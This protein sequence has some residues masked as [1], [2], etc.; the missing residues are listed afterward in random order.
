VDGYLP[1]Y[2]DLHLQRH[3]LYDQGVFGFL[4]EQQNQTLADWLDN[5]MAKQSRDGSEIVQE[6]VRHFGEVG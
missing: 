5:T 6:A 1:A 3:G 4:Q 2:S